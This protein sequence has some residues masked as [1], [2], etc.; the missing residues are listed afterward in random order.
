MIL[1]DRFFIRLQPLLAGTTPPFP[2]RTGLTVKKALYFIH[3]ELAHPFDRGAIAGYCGVSEDYLSRIFHRE[4]G[5]ALWDYV[6]CLRL[7]RAH[8]LLLETAAPI[9]EIAAQCGFSGDEYFS[10]MFR[11]QYGFPPGSLRR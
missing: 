3:T 7:G 6:L 10:R 5:M 8:T 11:R 4:Q 1:S 9:A 2:A